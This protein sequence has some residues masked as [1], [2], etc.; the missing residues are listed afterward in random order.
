MAPLGDLAGVL[1][2][3]GMTPY[4]WTVTVAA[5]AVQ[6]IKTFSSTFPGTN[7]SYLDIVPA[8]QQGSATVWGMPQSTKGIFGVSMNY[9]ANTRSTSAAN[10]DIA[11]QLT[12]EVTITMP[13][14]MPVY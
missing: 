4:N 11:E 2:S 7:P 13:I 14:Y 3:Q 9:N 1:Y 10:F 6:T 5:P 8:G 12:S